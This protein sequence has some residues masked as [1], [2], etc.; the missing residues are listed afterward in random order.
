MTSR[1]N[2]IITCFQLG[3]ISV[4]EV[5]VIPKIREIMVITDQVGSM[6]EPREPLQQQH[7]V[8]N[9]LKRTCKQGF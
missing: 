9:S 8:E 3:V 4:T 1:R 7:L 2:K 6:T 5:A